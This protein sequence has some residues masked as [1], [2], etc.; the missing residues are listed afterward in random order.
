MNLTHGGGNLT[1][2]WLHTDLT[3]FLATG[4]CPF[5][6]PVNSLPTATPFG[7][8]LGVASG[9]QRRI[10]LGTKTLVLDM[11]NRLGHNW[12]QFGHNGRPND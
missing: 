2:V 7:K 4:Y 9:D 12:S 8:L 6:N 10:I 1:R 3:D 5:P 11:C